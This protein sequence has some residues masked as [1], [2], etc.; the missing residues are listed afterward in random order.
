MLDSLATGQAMSATIERPADVKPFREAIEAE[1]GHLGYADQIVRLKDLLADARCKL[2]L[3]DWQADYAERQL[4]DRRN[5]W[6]E[7]EGKMH[8]REFSRVQ[9]EHAHE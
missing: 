3:K 1:V 8:R 4:R 2:A 6:D 5:R 9:E 7:T